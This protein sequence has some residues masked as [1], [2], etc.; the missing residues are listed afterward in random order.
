MKKEIEVKIKLNKDEI[1]VLKNKLKD[2]GEHKIK[3]KE[4]ETTYGFFTQ[5]N[6][7]IEKGIFPRIK[8]INNSEAAIFTV[9]VRK[10]E[11][12]SYFQRDEHE[13]PIK[14][15]E[16]MRDIVK[17]FGFTK[18]RVFEK[19]RETWLIDNNTVEV[20]FD[21]L[22]FGEY[23]EIEAE[24]EKIEKWIKVLELENK[25]RINKAYLAVFD[26]WRKKNNVKEENAIFD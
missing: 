25:E 6:S 24:P 13:M 22:P 11:D 14:D 7:S 12:N 21:S 9:K 10:T 26:D 8:S 2:I 4:K 20:N 3:P 23:I 19:I 17:I 18:E 5:D 1:G 15:I 16:T